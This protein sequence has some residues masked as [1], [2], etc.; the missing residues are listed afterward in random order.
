MRQ[1]IARVLLP[2][3]AAAFIVSFFLMM[4][5]VEPFYTFFFL[6]A[7]WSFLLM[8][9]SWLFLKGGESLIL[10]KPVEFLGFLVPLS[11]FIWF[12]FEAFNL[13]LANWAYAGVP[14]NPWLRWP[15]NFL[16]FGTVL[17]GI[18][19]TVNFMERVKIFPRNDFSLF[20]S[21]PLPGRI[22][23]VSAASGA[24]MLALPLLWPNLFFPLVWGG[25]VLLLDPWVARWK[26][27]SLL[28]E[29][30]QKNFSRTLQL[31]LAGFICGGLWEFWNFWAGAK[32]IYTVPLP[33]SLLKNL[34]LFEMPVLGFLGFPPFALECFVMFEFTKCLK[35]RASSGVWK[36]MVLSAFTFMLLMCRMMDKHTVIS[37]ID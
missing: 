7:W 35:E 12:I 16:A 18:F 8:L 3:S 28:Q 1:S 32:W 33:E 27:K 26:G 10:E 30:R 20:F 21:E 9:D 19:L 17:P 34:K 14:A 4:R 5:R 29:W 15:G 2:L 11:A 31:L 37:I 25:F 6:F 23:A 24:L 22:F 13:R 36:I